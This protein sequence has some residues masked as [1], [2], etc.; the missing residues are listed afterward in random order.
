METTGIAVVD[1]EALARAADETGAIWAC[2]TDDLNANLVSIVPGA[3]IAEH[4]NTEVDVLLVGIEG[5]GLV[6]IDGVPQALTTG[7]ATVI[8]KG[9][10]RSIRCE[11]GRLS[12]LTCH[13]RRAGMWPQNLRFSGPDSENPSF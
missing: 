9:V 12:Y 4:V 10:R 5:E 3:G 8:P 11:H 1:L 6:F 13:R 7:R 2:R